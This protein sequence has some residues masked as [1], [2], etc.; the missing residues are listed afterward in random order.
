M[1]SD[2]EYKQQTKQ[3]IKK[4]RERIC[5]RLS[6]CPNL[7]VYPASANFVLIKILKEDVTSEYLFETAIKKGYMIRDCSTFPFLDNHYIRFCFMEPE[8]NDKLVDTILEVVQ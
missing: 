6:D 7:K 8:Q 3:L 2:E 4:E 5:K 1:F